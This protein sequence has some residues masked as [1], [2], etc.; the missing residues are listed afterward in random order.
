MTLILT[1]SVNKMLMLHFRSTSLNVFSLLG[2]KKDLSLLWC[3]YMYHQESIPVGCVPP[4]CQPYIFWWP[5]LGV[6]TRVVSTNTWQVPCLEG[7]VI[8]STH[9]RGTLHPWAPPP[10]RDMRQGYLP[11]GKDMGPE[12]P[13]PCTQ[14]DTCEFVYNFVGVR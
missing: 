12:T 3:I 8:V 9:P 13:T 11:H 6:S 7:R 14:T 10:R 4:A 5:P 2:E 1:E